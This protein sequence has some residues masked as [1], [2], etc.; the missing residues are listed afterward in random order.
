M[1]RPGPAVH[2][3]IVVVDVEG[4][5][6]HSRTNP[7]RVAVRVGLH[8]VVQQAFERAGVSWA[9]CDHEDCGDGIFV[10]APAEMPK[11]LFVDAVPHAMVTALREHNT[12]HSAEAQ[13]RLR[14]ALHAGEVMYDQ[15]GRTA[16]ALNLAFRLLD[17]APL[18]TA[19]ADSP[20]VLAVIT[21]GWFF[22]EVVRHSSVSDAST[23]RPVRVT[24]KE[25]STLAWI[26][27]PDYPYPPAPANLA[28]L[29]AENLVDSASRRFSASHSFTGRL[30][31]ALVDELAVP[32]QLPL[33]VRDFTGRAEYLA[34]LDALLLGDHV[35]Q[36]DSTGASSKGA[37]VI[38]AIDGT[39]GVGKTALAV[40][41]AHRV[42]HR[43]PDGTLYVNLRGY[44]PGHPATPAEVLDG[45]LRALGCPRERI[46]IGLEAQSALYRSLLAGRRILIVLDNANTS[47]QV[48][49]LLPGSAGCLVL[50]T[51]RGSLTGLVVN[52]A[53]TRLTLDLLTSTEALDLVRGILGADRVAAEPQAVSRLI[54]IC[55]HLPLALR[56]A[57]SRLASRAHHSVSDVVAEM[58]TDRARLD[59]LS[60]IGDDPIAVR[61]VFD[62]SYRRLDEYQARLFRRLGLHPGP[63]ISLHAAAAV[64]DLD[65]TETRRL[66]DL[67]VDAHL[68]EAVARDRYR[69]HDL[70]RVYAAE[71]A[72]HDEPSQDRDR[73]RHAV[74]EWYAHYS[75]AAFRAMF[76]REIG[77]HPLLTLDLHAGP[78]IMFADTTDAWTWLKSEQANLIA[79]ANHAA[80]H[81]LSKL[82]IL[83]GY[84]ASVVPLW[85]GEWNAAFDL[86]RLELYVARRSGDRLCEWHALTDMAIALAGVGRQAEALASLQE[87]LALAKTLDEPWFEAGTLTDLGWDY[88]KQGRYAEAID[89]LNSALPLSLDAQR[90]RLEGV[91]ETGLSAAHI[92]LGHYEQALSH[93]E[94]SLAICRQAGDQGGEGRALETI[95]RVKQGMG[96]HTEAIVLCERALSFTRGR[97]QPAN[98]AITLDTLGTSLQHIGD[99]GRALRCWREAL[100]IFDRFADPRAAQ[101]R[102]RLHALEIPENRLS[103]EARAT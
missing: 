60:T 87:A 56:I 75:S 97:A 80:D 61:A 42:Q 58:D 20:G 59:A 11:A 34:A 39:A 89:H 46:P 23:Y 22:D 90:G 65:L 50:I 13:I 32:R 1:G 41:W 48:R 69:L 53:A 37:V 95:A 67:L 98:T 103:I 85:L 47:Q 70:L 94:R 82:A 26:S 40:H 38:S 81:N 25:T 7:H 55:S 71:R 30:A 24:V 66:L 10:L 44:G 17:A 93:A 63:E 52:E 102:T 15:H 28:V 36:G 83:I 45:F 84:T 79:A 33:A 91:I 12:T 18:K 78:S 8:H 101:L 62:W 19:L 76:P 73:A 35:D 27:L 49:P 99:L 43:F 77:W 2:R 68:L 3:T 92:G 6:D 9:D 64:A 51:S 14:M 72:E 74:L 88:L 96:A 29:P 21:S 57:A 5:G 4:F 100:E 31:G 16:A 54:Q 86:I